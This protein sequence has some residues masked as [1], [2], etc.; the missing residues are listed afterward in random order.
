MPESSRGISLRSEAFAFGRERHDWHVRTYT[1]CALSQYQRLLDAF[2]SIFKKRQ[3]R[4]TK[5]KCAAA[6]P[7]LISG[8]D[9]YSELI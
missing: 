6:S 2:V 1:V 4:N 3:E 9:N 8:I 7:P 5:K